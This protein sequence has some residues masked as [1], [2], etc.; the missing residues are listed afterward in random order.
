MEL[1]LERALD[2]RGNFSQTP[3]IQHTR[4]PQ[5]GISPKQSIPGMNNRPAGLGRHPSNILLEQDTA[6]SHL[7]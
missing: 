5:V 1:A 2:D 3:H 6:C 4:H 7:S